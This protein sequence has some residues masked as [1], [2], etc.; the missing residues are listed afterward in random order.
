MVL[1]DAVSVITDVER[2]CVNVSGSPALAKAGSGDVL[3]GLIAGVAVREEPFEAASVGAYVLG[4]AGELAA[5]ARG[6]YSVTASM[7]PE[8]IGRFIAKLEE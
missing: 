1:K 8:F 4:R 7:L 3:S 6:D 5:K 2:V